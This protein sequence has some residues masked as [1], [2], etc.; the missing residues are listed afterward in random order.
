MFKLF[1]YFKFR[2]QKGS[3]IRCNKMRVIEDLEDYT[4]KTGKQMIKG[5][6]VICR[7]SVFVFRKKE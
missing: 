1:R 6:C 3:C 2:G 4:T 5:H 7:S